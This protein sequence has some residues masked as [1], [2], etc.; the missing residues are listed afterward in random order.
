[1]DAQFDIY[2]KKPE[3]QESYRQTFTVTLK[4]G[5]TLLEVFHYIHE[6]LDTTFT[7]RYSCRG[8]ICGSCAV[9]IN[10]VAGLAC[11]TQVEE[12]ATNGV[13]VVDP[14][15]N[16]QPIRDLV[17]DLEPFWQA[18][19]EII[20]YIKREKE[21]HNEVFASGLDAQ[22]LDQ[23]I[24][25]ITCIKCGACFS[26]C[27]KRAQTE[28]FVGPAAAAALYKYYFDSRDGAL[29]ERI[30]VASNPESGVV[31][32]DSFAACL[33]VCPKDVRPLKAI[34]QIRQ[35]LKARQESP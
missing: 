7:Y 24:R 5:M 8:A 16:F 21:E 1:M 27:D 25:A 2:R 9:R 31:V 26:D 11:K 6:H 12:L 17:V 15:G 4:P 3:V 30:K 35:D 33:K 20:P 10:G 18:Y 23:M 32:C 28:S 22:H 19:R 34:N 14:L 13:I 29:E